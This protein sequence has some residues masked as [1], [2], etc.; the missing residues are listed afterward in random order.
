MQPNIYTLIPDIYETI[1][2]K[3]GWFH[4]ELAAS[5]SKGLASVLQAHLGETK[6]P[7]L[8]LSQMGPKCPKQLWH[9]IRTPELAEPLPPQ[10]EIKFTYG[11]IL[12]HLAIML[13][14]ASGHRVEGE[15]DELE[16]DGI[17][18]HR[19]CVIDG[20]IVDVKSCSSMAFRKFKEKT[21][22][23]SDSFGY[24]DQLDGYLVGS[25]EDPLVTNK[26]SAFILA[27][28]KTL[29]HL[30]LYEHQLREHSI[31]E[32]ITRYKSIISEAS[33]PAC[34]CGTVA[35]GKSGNIKLDTR[36]SYSSYKHVCFPNLRTFLYAS[37]PIYL[38]HVARKPDVLEV[39]RH[40]N[41]VYN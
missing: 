32:R 4:D 16:V 10:A 22:H 13:A 27:I 11:H 8:R 23:A 3:D 38:S 34:T 41:Q 30:C 2:K 5:F 9:S 1:Q 29:G 18:G 35:D 12:E 36:A 31:R 37:G 21:L 24:L 39:D 28:D 14:K 25:S 7:R 6:A 17:R 40:G 15:Q 20:N 26:T 19:D 33:P